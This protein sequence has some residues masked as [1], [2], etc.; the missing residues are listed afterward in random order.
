[1]TEIGVNILNSVH[2]ADSAVEALTNR[3]IYL[4]A[5]FANGRAEIDVA[6][7]I[8]I[9]INIHQLQ[10][11]HQVLID[12]PGPVDLVAG[13]AGTRAGKQGGEGKLIENEPMEI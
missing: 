5:Q 1:M 7:G 13:I 12:V 4:N 3:S 2:Q 6:A 10:G 11:L 8:E 9:V